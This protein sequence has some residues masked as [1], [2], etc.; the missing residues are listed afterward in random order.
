MLASQAAISLENAKLYSD[1]HRS[2]AFLAE[3]QNI[4]QTGSFGWSVFSGEIYWSKE[5]YKIFEFDPAVKPT[6][7]LARQRI[8]PHDRDHVHHSLDHATNHN[9]DININH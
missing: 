7:E 5:T 8:H 1:L 3:G 4:S 2:E 9:P 6:L